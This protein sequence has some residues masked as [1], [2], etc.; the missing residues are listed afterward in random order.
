M[1]KRQLP[2]AMANSLSLSMMGLVIPAQ[3]GQTMNGYYSQIN[4]LLG[5]PL[6][7]VSQ[8]V[9][10]VFLKGAAVDK[11]NGQK[12]S[13]TFNTVAKW[14]ALISILPFGILLLWGDPLLPWF[15]GEDWRPI[16]GYLKYLTPLFMVRFVV[17]PLTSSAIALG[18]QKASMLWQFCLLASVGI[19]SLLA[20]ALS[21]S[22]EQY[23]SLIHI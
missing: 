23:L 1:Y 4:T 20:F 14:L 11:H 19:P 12:L 8:S 6:V 10:Q 16:A 2:S 15:L 5:Q 17:T 7:L 21:M 3:F 22:F 9:A 18:K 13:R